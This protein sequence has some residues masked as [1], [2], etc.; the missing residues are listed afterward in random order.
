MVH[1]RGCGKQLHE[2]AISCPNCGASQSMPKRQ[3]A[4]RSGGAVFLIACGW[5]LLIWFALV[6]VISAI[7]AMLDPGDATAAR[8]AGEYFSGLAFVVA[9]VVAAA[10]SI[11]GVLPGTSR[12]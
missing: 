11:T 4:S 7:A 12:R 10:L 9:A 5:T 6:I 1:C 2:S 8:R 3:P